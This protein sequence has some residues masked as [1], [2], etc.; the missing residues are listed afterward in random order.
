M[1]S[2]NIWCYSIY[3]EKKAA[4]EKNDFHVNISGLSLNESFKFFVN[5]ENAYHIDDSP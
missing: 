2:H 5:K 3:S 1:L 4:F